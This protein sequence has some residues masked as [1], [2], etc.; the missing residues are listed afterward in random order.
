[1]DKFKQFIQENR[2]ELDVEKP[3]AHL[4]EQMQQC[5]EPEKPHKKVFPIYRWIA[6]AACILLVSTISYFFFHKNNSQEVPTYAQKEAPVMEPTNNNIRREDNVPAHLEGNP[7]KINTDHIAKAEKKTEIIEKKKERKKPASSQYV[8]EDVE[9]GNFS[10]VIAYQRQY[11]N[12][13][14]IYGQQPDYFNDFK[15]QLKQ[16]DS[17]EKNV[18]NDIKK[19]GLNSKQIELLINIY[20]QKITLLKQLNQEISRINKSFY[21]NHLQK[22]SVKMENPHFLNL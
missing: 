2:Q 11:I 4:W 15:Q 13:L 9:V 14:P 16:M 1:M 20:Q 17:D 3:D 21:Q 19:H 12:T 18:R 6:A 5:L 7:S 8:I 10:Q 22:D